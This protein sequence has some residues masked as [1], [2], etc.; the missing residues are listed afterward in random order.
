MATFKI[1]VFAHQQRD[2]GRFPISIRITN[3]RRSVYLNTGMYATRSQISKDFST[4]KDRVIARAIDRKIQEFEELIAQKLGASVGNYS[5]R[6]LANFLTKQ[7]SD[8]TSIDFVEFA[9]E[10]IQ[11]IAK[12]ENRKS[13]AQKIGSTIK[14]LTDYFGRDQ[15]YIREITAKSLQGFADFLVQNRQVSERT[16][17]DYLTNIRTLFNAAIDKYN[18]EDFGVS[19]I[20]H[21]PFR[22][23]KIKSRFQSKSRNLSVSDIRRIKDATDEELVTKRA[24]LA[25]DVF[26]LSFYL[27]GTNLIDLYYLD[28]YRDGRISYN[29]RK[30]SGRREDG[31][32]I[33]IKVEPE[34]EGLL[35]KYR[36][37]TGERAL[38]FH[39][40]Y[41]SHTDFVK[42]VNAGLKQLAE[43]IG[44]EAPVTSYWARHSWATIARNDCGVS[45]DDINLALNHVDKDMAVTD[46]Y[47]AKDWS[48]IDRANHKV[49]MTLSTE[50]P[51][52]VK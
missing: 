26:M 51:Y 9:N 12:T 37:K 34:A 14:A 36:D 6:E 19:V 31:A 7:S 30:T 1:C 21:Y 50:K 27:V 48:I 40:L 18:D 29:R 16:V 35:E 44:L 52:N 15:I 45:K 24:I 25:R 22:K 47:I 32:Y 39:N 28:E 10:H 3:N 41:G 46:I 38:C 11:S 23:L 13:Y 43:S 20:T 17:S 42:N 49:I 5:A 8:D 33:S 2:D 4:V